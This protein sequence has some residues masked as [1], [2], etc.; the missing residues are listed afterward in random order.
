MRHVFLNLVVLVADSVSRDPGSAHCEA[1]ERCL[2]GANSHRVHN[3]RLYRSVRVLY[4]SGGVSL[5]F[6]LHHEVGYVVV[7][8]ARGLIHPTIVVYPTSLH[9][10]D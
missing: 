8:L 7:E 6:S 5:L 9:A 3:T 1:S 2:K 4:E 10:L